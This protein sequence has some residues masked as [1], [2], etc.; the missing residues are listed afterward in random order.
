[1]GNLNFIRF[2]CTVG[3]CCGSNTEYYRERTR[4]TSARN[5]QILRNAV[6][7]YGNDEVDEHV[8]E[9]RP[10]KRDTWD[11]PTDGTFL[12]DRRRAESIASDPTYSDSYREWVVRKILPKLRRRKRRM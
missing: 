11:E 12:Y 6:A 3:I 9:Y 2:C 8:F 7:H 5:K 10:P 4:R 1:M